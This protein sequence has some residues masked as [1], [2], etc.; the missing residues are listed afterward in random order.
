MR[1]SRKKS[2]KK[3]SKKNRIK[4]DGRKKKSKCSGKI[5]S[6]MYLKQRIIR[7]FDSRK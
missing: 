1:F 5:S 3:I 6:I 4:E 7:M 2:M